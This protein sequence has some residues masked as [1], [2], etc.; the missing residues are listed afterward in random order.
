MR[1]HV[2]CHVFAENLAGDGRYARAVS[3]CS[4]LDNAIKV[5]CAFSEEGAHHTLMGRVLRKSISSQELHNQA[6]PN[7]TRKSS[8]YVGLPDRNR[9]CQPNS[10]CHVPI[11]LRAVPDLQ[12]K[13]VL[14]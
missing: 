8:S 6:T 9:H 11:R 13:E 1:V 10:I 5:S 2:I 3:A 12:G 4:T 7:E 14:Q